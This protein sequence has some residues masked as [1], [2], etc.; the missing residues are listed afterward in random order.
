MFISGFLRKLNNKM[1]SRK[2]K[3]EVKDAKKAKRTQKKALKKKAAVSTKKK[4]KKK[5]Y[6]MIATNEYG[7]REIGKTL[8][9]V[10]E[11]MKGRVINVNL[12]HLTGDMKKQNVTITFKVVNIHENKGVTEAI[13]YEIS[14]AQVKRTVR[15]NKNK[16][17]DSFIVET[18]DKKRARVKPL[19]LTRYRTSQTKA[20]EL[21]KKVR[22]LLIDHAKKSDFNTF[23]FDA[24]INKIQKQIK[25]DTRKIYPIQISE[26]RMIKLLL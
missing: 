4:V 1:V 2:K 3:Q 24:V 20:S 9:E 19:L 7:N 25:N 17:D 26:I 14:S 6:S 22:E 16:I 15:K 5:W 23:L 11:N 8:A 18:K 10:P 13:N 21:R 12:A